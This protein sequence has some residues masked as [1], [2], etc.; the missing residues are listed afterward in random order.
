MEPFANDFGGVEAVWMFPF[1]LNSGIV[2]VA[3]ILQKDMPGMKI[4]VEMSQKEF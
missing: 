2:P 1:V 3:Q 4:R